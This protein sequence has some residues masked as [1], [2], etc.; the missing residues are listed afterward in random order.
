[1]INFGELEREVGGTM[2]MDRVHAEWMLAVLRAIEPRSVIEIGCYAGVS[3]TAIMHAYDDGS[4]DEVHLV[5]INIQAQVRAMANIRTRVEV[6]EM[7]SFQ[8][9]PLIDAASDLVAVIDGDHSRSVVE[10]ELALVLGKSPAA[11]IAHDVTA[12]AAGYGLCDG[13]RWLWERLQADGWNCVVDCRKRD[14]AS[15]H[16]GLLVACRTPQYVDAV[17]QAWAETCGH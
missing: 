9:L 7:T 12:E 14:N 15:T 8:A 16:R 5:D 11:I 3:T 10:P 13:A 4:V 17:R 1:V 6:Y 2:S